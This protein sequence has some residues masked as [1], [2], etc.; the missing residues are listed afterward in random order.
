MRCKVTFLTYNLQQELL[1]FV[2]NTLN[3]H[4]AFYFSAILQTM[5]DTNNTFHDK[6]SLPE[7]EGNNS[8]MKTFLSVIL[9]AVLFYYFISHNI[10]LIGLIV[11]VLFVHEIGHYWMMKHYKYENMS[12]IFVPFLGAMVQG[13]K[14]TAYSQ[15]E[16]AN[17]ILAGP[18]PGIVIGIALFLAGIHFQEL[19]LIYAGALFAFINILNLIPLDPLD[20]GQ[21]LYLLFFDRKD[22]LRLYFLLGSS[23]LIIGVGTY[24]NN[25]IVIA[26][27]FLLGIRVRAY[28]KILNIHN[29]LRAEGIN[30]VRTYESLSGSEF[31]AIKRVILENSALAKKM[32]D[33]DFVATPEFDE[34]MASEVNSVLETP[35]VVDMSLTKKLIYTSIW[36][37]CFVLVVWVFYSNLPKVM[38]II[39]F[40]KD[41]PEI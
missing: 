6:P 19:Y 35:V 26:F 14:S 22:V 31:N 32:V 16:R 29:A 28:Q 30:Y 20:G 4:S 34:V 36:V 5:S 23:L 37:A 41:V 7:K 2:H 24:F 15:L 27:G 18:V 40:L 12:M 13:K 8:F 17:V 25:F 39:E 11:L 33:S 21:L 1:F 38:E 3:T 10:L 9:F